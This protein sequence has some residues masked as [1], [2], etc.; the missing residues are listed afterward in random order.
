MVC[1]RP[2][3]CQ[4]ECKLGA[5]CGGRALAR[6]VWRAFQKRLRYNAVLLK[7]VAR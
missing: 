2:R 7:D 3:V 5:P 6:I 4:P 1:H